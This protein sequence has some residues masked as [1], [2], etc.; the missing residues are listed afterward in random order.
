MDQTRRTSIMAALVVAATSTV[1][2]AGISHADT[3][4]DPSYRQDDGPTCVG[5]NPNIVDLPF[6][7]KVTA[8]QNELRSQHNRLQVTTTMLGSV[9]APYTVDLSLRATNTR[10]RATVSATLTTRV[11]KIGFLTPF[12]SVAYLDDRPYD[13][14]IHPGIGP[15]DITV[16]AQPHGRVPVGPVTCRVNTVVS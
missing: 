14:Y 4:T 11:D 12:Y 16:V 9:A 7:I 8:Y 5:T 15:V 6:T 1:L 13:G 2:G 3:A 10:T